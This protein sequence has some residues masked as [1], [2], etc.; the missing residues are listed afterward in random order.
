LEKSPAGNAPTSWKRQNWFENSAEEH[1][2]VRE[3]I[4]MYDMTSFG[5]I[6]VEGADACKYL[7]YICGNDVDVAVGKI[8]YTQFLNERAG[9]EADVTVT[10]LGETSYI[11]VTP[12]ATM[13]RELHW[14]NK[15]KGD[16]N[17]VLLD[18]TSAE[19]VLAVMGP[20]SRKLLE[21]V[22]PNHDWGN[23]NHPFGQANDIELG[24]GLARAH[25]VTY[26]G[27]LGS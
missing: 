9:I 5:K 26:V 16:F 3:N 1:K 7:N 11:I 17:I 21:K 15:H 20:N 24:M 4:G 12:A 19:G 18:M 10:R 23:D 8:V 27:E 14:M 13:Q 25:R 6:R 2:A 22:A